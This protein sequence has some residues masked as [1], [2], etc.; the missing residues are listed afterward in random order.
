MEPSNMGREDWNCIFPSLSPP[1]QSGWNIPAKP[2]FSDQARQR[3]GMITVLKTRK[4][5]PRTL[6]ISPSTH[7]SENHS[8][9]KNNLGLNYFVSSIRCLRVFYEVNIFEWGLKDYGS[10]IQRTNTKNAYEKRWF[11]LPRIKQGSILI[12]NFSLPLPFFAP[13]NCVV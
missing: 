6:P 9:F 3:K 4:A 13:D 12:L 7:H 11:C 8:L 2:R 5:Q 10:T 1:L